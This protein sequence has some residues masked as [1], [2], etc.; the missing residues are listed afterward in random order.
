M[1]LIGQTAIGIFVYGFFHAHLQKGAKKL[2][3]PEMRMAY[4]LSR[5]FE[6][7]Y[8]CSTFLIGNSSIEIPLKYI[9]CRFIR[10]GINIFFLLFTDYRMDSQLFHNSVDSVF[11]VRCMIEMVDPGCHSPIS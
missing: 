7:R 9:F 4:Q 2:T 8:I 11:A 3:E 10:L 5:Y 1:P 6:F